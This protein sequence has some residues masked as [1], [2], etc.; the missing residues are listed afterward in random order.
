MTQAALGIDVACTSEAAH[1]DE[2]AT[3]R[4]LREQL[5]AAHRQLGD[6]QG[7]LAESTRRPDARPRALG[8]NVVPLLRVRDL[9]EM[10]QVNARTIRRWRDAR[11]L[12][13]ALSIEGVVRW[14]PRVVHEWLASRRETKT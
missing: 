10:L 3:V 9:A 14:E 6:L 4:Q 7:Q 8:S 1:F 13:P 2:S 11:I 5:A 12:P